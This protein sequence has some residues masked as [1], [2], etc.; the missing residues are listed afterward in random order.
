VLFFKTQAPIEP[1][2]FVHRMCQDARDATGKRTSRYVK[3]LSPATQVGKATEKGID[4]LSQAV[5][6]PHFHSEVA[7]SRKVR[8]PFS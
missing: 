7:I 5:L 3:R 8:R 6:A 2:A 4:E 1:A